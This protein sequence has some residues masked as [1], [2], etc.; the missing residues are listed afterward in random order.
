MLNYI[1]YSVAADFGICILFIAPGFSIIDQTRL[2]AV[3]FEAAYSQYRVSYMD[4]RLLREKF[5]EEF[6]KP[7]KAAFYPSKTR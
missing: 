3:V 7:L 6:A 4:V 2:Y 5:I 1:S